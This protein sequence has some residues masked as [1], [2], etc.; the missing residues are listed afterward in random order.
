M[1]HY[2]L[3]LP[4]GFSS[5]EMISASCLYDALNIFVSVLCNMHKMMHVV[6]VLTWPISF[7]IFVVVVE[8]LTVK[9]S[10]D[11]NWDIN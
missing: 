6:N 5:V 2:V 9:C 10:T 7:S 4:S 8:K 11:I 1:P 3:I